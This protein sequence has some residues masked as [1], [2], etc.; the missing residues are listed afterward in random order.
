MFCCFRV[1]FRWDEKGVLIIEGIGG[2]LQGFGEMKWIFLGKC[3][4]V[5]AV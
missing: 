4:I 5:G 3:G 1:L 2:G